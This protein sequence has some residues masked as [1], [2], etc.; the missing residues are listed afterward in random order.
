MRVLLLLFSGSTVS[1][2]WPHHHGHS[3]P[4]TP[5]VHTAVSITAIGNLR[6]AGM[7][8]GGSVLLDT[9][10]E[11]KVRTY[12]VVPWARICLRMQGTRVGSP[13]RC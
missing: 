8:G 5:L 11:T 10:T 7:G 2:T 9:L 6:Q 1:R 12:L 4:S 13:G 3:R